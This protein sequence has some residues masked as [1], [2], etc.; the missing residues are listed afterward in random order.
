MR[1]VDS[2]QKKQVPL[3]IVGSIG[4]Q[5][6][7]KMSSENTYNMVV[8]G[9]F[10]VPAP[11]YELATKILVGSS[12]EGRAIFRSVSANLLVVVE[13]S[14][15][16]T[17]STALGKSFRGNLDTSTGP[18]FISENNNREIAI[19]DGLLLYVLR[20]DT[21]SFTRV[22]L[23]FTPVYI[24]YQ[25]GYFIAATG[26][27]NQWRLSDLNNAMSWP[28]DVN[29]VGLLQSKPADVTV[30]TVAFNRQL[31]VFGKT[32]TEIWHDVGNTLFPYQRDNT[33][34]INV[35][36]YAVESLSANFNYVVWLASN[37]SGSPTL[38]YSTGGA[39]ITFSD[40]GIQFK[41]SQLTNPQNCSGFLY[42]ESGHIYYQITFYDDNVS[43][44]YDFDEKRFST[45][46]DN[47]LNHH[48]A[49]KGAFFDNHNFFISK[50]NGNLYKFSSSITTYDR[51]SIPYIRITKNYRHANA[52]RTI[53]SRL[54]LNM[55]QGASD[56]VQ[57]VELSVSRNGGYSYGNVATRT[58]NTLGNYSNRLDF[59]NLG[60]AN[61]WVFQFRFYAGNTS[62]RD[63]IPSR[64]ATERFV[65]VGGMMEMYT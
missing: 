15:V 21:F 61:D 56:Q 23:D 45:V 37:E 48:I 55:E 1:S 6:F 57:V 31:F 63:M 25:D 34:E 5:R 44:I 7:T 8:I 10:L 30:A 41:I 22:T 19:V 64:N 35:G 60:S 50:N 49:R 58:L 62:P 29:G 43:W 12:V 65:I 20:T 46:T 53:V 4:F 42:S 59:W 24:D 51:E 54:T 9:D 32:V 3:D 11:G 14:Q 39:P 18:V 13:N 33:S 40:D 16:Y 47:A 27:T 2:L 28:A 36:L 38:V 52:A 17:I 26:I